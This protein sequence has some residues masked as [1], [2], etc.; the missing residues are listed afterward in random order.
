MFFVDKHLV[1]SKFMASEMFLTY[2]VRDDTVATFLIAS[3][4]LS[5]CA[6]DKGL[7]ALFLHIKQFIKKAMCNLFN[8]SVL[9]F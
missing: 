4:S 9:K 6:V 8:P 1:L 7:N 2:S 5:F 3:V